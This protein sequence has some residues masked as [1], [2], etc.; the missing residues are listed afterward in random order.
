MMFG[1]V[2]NRAVQPLNSQ[3]LETSDLNR[4]EFYYL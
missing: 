4:E 1:V 2:K 3:R